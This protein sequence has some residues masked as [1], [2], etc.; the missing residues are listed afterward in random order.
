[1]LHYH[2]YK[3]ADIDSLCIV[4]LQG[5]N[6]NLTSMTVSSDS[7]TVYAGSFDGRINILAYLHLFIKS[8]IKINACN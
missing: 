7:S 2:L 6:K 1:M 8:R 5:Q 3:P 4:F